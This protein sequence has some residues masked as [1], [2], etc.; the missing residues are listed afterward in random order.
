M[1]GGGKKGKKKGR[2]TR[3]SSVIN[4]RQQAISSV[5]FWFRR[6]VII[7]VCLVVV[8]WLMFW[9]FMT[10][11]DTRFS[12]TLDKRILAWSAQ[13]GFAVKNIL[14]EGR[15]YSD[16]AE[17]LSLLDVAE[18]DPIFGVDLKQ[19]K[20]LIENISWVKAAHLERRLPDT[21]FIKIDERMPFAL[22]GHDGKIELIDDEGVVLTDKDL[23][24]FKDLLMVRGAGANLV[25][26]DILGLL[27]A[28]PEILSRV[29]NAHLV[30]KRRWNLN[31]KDGKIIKLPESDIGLALR[32]LVKKQEEEGILDKAVI[33]IDVRDSNRF[34]VQTE[35][36]KAQD[37]EVGQ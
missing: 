26:G 11:S 34:V 15:T 33:S 12:D 5:F 13:G 3:R 7:G 29:D 14:V 6:L 19:S 36:G 28:E 17:I 10:Y 8:T 37:A 21:L 27:N 35:S 23:A 25:A 31:L 24:R 16:G 32:R 30:D 22:W 4:R 9:G 1:F 2:G 18:G 20:E